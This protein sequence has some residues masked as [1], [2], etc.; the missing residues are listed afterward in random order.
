MGM[1]V[2]T[3][4]KEAGFVLRD[5]RTSA[6]R[7]RWEGF[8]ASGGP[9]IMRSMLSTD[10]PD[11]SRLRTLV[12][13]AFTPRVVEG[14]RPQ[15][16]AIVDEALSAAA[17]QGGLELIDQ[18]AYPL[19]VTVIADMLGVPP[20]DWPRFRQWSS[21]LVA[22]LDPVPVFEPERTAAFLAAREGLTGYLKG[23][24]AER[25]REPCDDLIS[26]LIAVEEQGDALSEQELITM[27]NLLLV[28]GHETT[29]NLLGNGVLALLRN[30]EQLALLR[31][32]PELIESG[33]EEL[34][35]WDSPVQL[36]GRVAL[37]ELELDGREV[38][39]G[40]MLLVL[41]GAANRDPEQFEEPHRLDL[42]RDPNSHLG[43]GYGLHYCLGAPLARLETA[44][45]L[46]RLLDRRARIELA[47]D[48]PRW[49]PNLMGRA[50]E[51]LQVRLA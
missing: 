32:R 22:G 9:A 27:L 38:R 2:L 46:S 14:L 1:W 23:V 8:Q 37:A 50:V 45:A 48:Q 11:H 3:R 40:E 47:G 31:E 18:L 15:V 17:R 42:A 13:K 16:E 29:V 4:Y 26:R 43:F 7:T 20:H 12:N 36:T 10:P 19:P 24:V 51:N 6:D 25:R 5:P 30:P 49:R 33:V 39:P 35:R 21:A 44:I 41:L 34:L 28:A